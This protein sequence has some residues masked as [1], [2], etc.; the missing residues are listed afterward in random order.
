VPGGTPPPPAIQLDRFVAGSP[1]Q[2]NVHLL[3]PYEATIRAGGSVNFIISGFHVVAIYDDGHQPEQI[4]VPPPPPLGSNF[5]DDPNRRLYRGL[6]PSTL[7]TVQDRVEVVQFSRPGRYLVICAFRP[8]FVTDNMH[9][10]VRV[11]P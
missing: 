5:I 9:G 7:G 4:I 10:F 11:L 2:A 3:I 1:R 8:H 6:D